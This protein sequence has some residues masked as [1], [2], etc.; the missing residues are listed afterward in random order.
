MVETVFKGVL[1]AL[2][3][4]LVLAVLG[5]VFFKWTLDTSPYLAGLASFLGLIY[6]VLPIQNLKPL[7]I[8][9]EGLMAFRI[10]ISIIK[11]IWQLL[12]ISA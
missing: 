2:V 4:A 10:I 11:V 12:P 8:C 3:I 6:Y 9:F 7:L 1:I 5:T